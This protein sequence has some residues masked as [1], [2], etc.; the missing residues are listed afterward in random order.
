MQ[1]KAADR[2]LMT[3]VGGFFENQASVISTLRILTP[4]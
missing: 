1:S 2:G 4:G 3:A